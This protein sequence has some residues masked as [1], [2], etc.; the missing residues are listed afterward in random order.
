MD[1]NYQP[2]T[3][4]PNGEFN[5][6][7]F[8]FIMNNGQKQKKSLLPSGNPKQRLIILIVG[9]LSA[10][11]L[12]LVLFVAI[13]SGGSSGTDQ[14]LALAQKQNEIIRIS[15]TG[16]TKA[17]GTEAKKLAALTSSTII[18]DQKTTVAYLAK[19]G[20]KVS[21]K[22]LARTANVTTDNELTAAERNG[23]FDEIFSRIMLEQLKDYKLSMQSSYASLGKTG[24]ELLCRND[25][26]VTLILNDNGVTNS[27]NQS[28]V[29][30]APAP[31]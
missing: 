31:Q 22:E 21:A 10:V 19:Q 11:V 20:K 24:R 16:N 13:F 17:G 30:S 25:N 3:P 6:S 27:P 26:H 8:D 29:E 12:I 23:R 2:P 18:S 28:C 1:P 7:Q 4:P 9:G 5:S 14:V 15:G